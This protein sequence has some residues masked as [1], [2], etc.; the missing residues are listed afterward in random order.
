MPKK[1]ADPLV[2]ILV[3]AGALTAYLVAALVGV[4]L[5]GDAVVGAAL[6]AVVAFGCFLLF[7]WRTTGRL[8]AA[9]GHGPHLRPSWWGWVLL[10]LVA[11]FALAQ[12][13]AVWLHTAV[14]SPAYDANQ[15]ARND[16]PAW[17]L[18]L[19]ALVVAPLGE[20][21]LMRGI[22]YTRLRRHLPVWAAVLA[23]SAVFAVL[24]G[25]IVQVAVGLVLG[26]FL[27]LVFEASGRLWHVVVLHALF[28]LM[29]ALV[30]REVVESAAGPFGV[31]MALLVFLGVMGGLVSS[32]ARHQHP[33]EQLQP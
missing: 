15:S 30:S 21:A 9:L 14:G 17:L 24:H 29:A 18:L 22:A 12:L 2:T 3:V 19:T 8:G 1:I 6:G 7:R 4:Q 23:T 26:T 25:N 33:L 20:E 32:S 10:G 16:S 31:V 27:A 13:L 5:F 28:N 11:T